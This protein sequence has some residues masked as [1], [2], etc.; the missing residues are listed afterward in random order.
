MLIT[1]SSSICDLLCK[2]LDCKICI[3]TDREKFKHNS[4]CLKPYAKYL[5]VKYGK[6]IK[7]EKEKEIIWTKPLYIDLHICLF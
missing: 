4:I 2:F 1:H 6:V 7:K 3:H 5:Y